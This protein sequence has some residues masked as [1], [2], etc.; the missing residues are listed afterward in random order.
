M[1]TNFIQVDIEDTSWNNKRYPVLLVDHDLFE[2][3][4]T[5][6]STV[7]LGTPNFSVIKRKCRQLNVID[8]HTDQP[9]TSMM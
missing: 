2:P 9:T 3:Q 6:T 1:K 5:G 4:N 8:R 7:R